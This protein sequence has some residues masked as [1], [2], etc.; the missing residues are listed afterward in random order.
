MSA[1]Q[2]SPQPPSPHLLA[3]TLHPD[4][5]PST[6]AP[7]PPSTTD[8]ASITT[9]LNS[10]VQSYRHEHGRRYHAFHEGAYYL[11]ND[12]IEISRLDIQHHMW[13]LT[14]NGA[15]YISP[16][17]PTVRNVIDIGTGTGQWAIEFADE[18]P[19]AAVL[20]TDLSPIQS[21]WTPPNCSFLINNA[22]EEWIFEDK[23]DFVHARMLMMGIHDWGK[24][25]RQAWDALTPGGWME[26]ME[27]EFPIGYMNDGSVSTDDPTYRYSDLIRQAAARAGIDTL[28]TRRFREMIEAQG[29]VNLRVEPA[30]WP[31]VAWPRGEKEKQLGKWTL[32]N[33]KQFM[34]PAG[35]ALFTKHLGWSKEEVEVLLVD[36]KADMEDKKKHYY[37][38]V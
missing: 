34:P 14:L 36:V 19:S 10:S 37:W 17:P 33:T 4:S 6:S 25:F 1:E 15:L 2:S 21:A 20:G 29:F 9:S 18:H 23:F 12:D 5:H 27:P 26:V 35:T 38:Q 16:L 24:F 30:K 7:S 11:P 3:Q 32:E 22:E 28:V 31:V 13:R 8:D